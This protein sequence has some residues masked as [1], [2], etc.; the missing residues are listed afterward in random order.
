M[1]FSKLD[2]EM[3]GVEIFRRKEF[4]DVVRDVIKRGMG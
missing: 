1:P 3:L 4:D 2:N